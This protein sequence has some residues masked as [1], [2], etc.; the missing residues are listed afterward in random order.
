MPAAAAGAGVVEINNRVA[1]HIGHAVLDREAREAGEES[2]LIGEAGC[3]IDARI[4][5][6]GV[7]TEGILITEIDQ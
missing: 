5:G 1:I 4:G 6:C 3:E 2:E 7:R